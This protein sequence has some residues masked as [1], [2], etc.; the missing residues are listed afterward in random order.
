[1]KDRSLSEELSPEREELTPELA[2]VERHFNDPLERSKSAL[3][4]D[5]ALRSHLS[6]FPTTSDWTA[7]RLPTST[8]SWVVATTA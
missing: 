2:L 6:Y 1:M 3:S 4:R 7:L 8:E 5:R